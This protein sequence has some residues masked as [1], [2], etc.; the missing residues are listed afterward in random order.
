VPAK[1]KRNPK[2]TQGFLVDENS[3][4]AGTMV[5]IVILLRSIAGCLLLFAPILGWAQEATADGIV[6]AAR[7]QIGKTVRYDPAYRALP[8]PNGDPPIEV[9]V[10]SD[11][12]IRALRAAL[13]MDL[14]QLVHEDMKRAFSDYPQNWG[15]KRPDKNIDHRRVPNLSAYFK[16]RG[17]ALPVM[18][19]AQDYRPGD[20]VICTV[21]PHLPHIMIVSDRTNSEGR[22]LV[23]HNIG[24]GTQEEDRLFEF[25]ITGH[26]RIATIEGARIPNA[27]RR[28]S[29][30]ATHSSTTAG[31][32]R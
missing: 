23:I 9:G 20:L 31:A 19:S 17:F 13:S 8:Y 3:H 16:R 32:S 21:P 22:P 24:A 10:C 26:Y 27:G 11:V 29:A 6:R 4:P 18:R 15:L 25:P 14:Q 1:R 30:S 7:A 5:P 2:I 28:T 12:V